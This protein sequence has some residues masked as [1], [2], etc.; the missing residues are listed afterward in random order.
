M[1]R[2]DL[3][4]K[5]LVKYINCRSLRPSE[6]EAKVF[7]VHKSK[8]FSYRQ[9]GEGDCTD[10]GA[11]GSVKRSSTGAQH[12]QGHCVQGHILS[13]IFFTFSMNAL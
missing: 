3:M 9:N 4:L 8:V 7:Q 2:I 13:Q 11:G 10:Y 5:V 12:C 1:A 6:T